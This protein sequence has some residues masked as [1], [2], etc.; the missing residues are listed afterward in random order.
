MTLLTF[1]SE[2][3]LSETLVAERATHAGDHWLLEQV[4]TTRLEGDRT[5]IGESHFEALGKPRLRRNC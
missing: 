4:Q 5:E 1:D 2:R 3:R